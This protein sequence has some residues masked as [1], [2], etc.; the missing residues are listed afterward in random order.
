MLAEMNVNWYA[1][2]VGY[3]PMIPRAVASCGKIGLVELAR[4]SSYRLQPLFVPDAVASAK[5]LTMVSKMPV[6]G[7]VARAV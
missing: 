5:S 6:I 7:I 3:L 2:P 1:C 4:I